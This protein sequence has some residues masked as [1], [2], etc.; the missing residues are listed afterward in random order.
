MGF[1]TVSDIFVDG[2]KS[3][4]A[5]NLNIKTRRMREKIMRKLAM[6]N[7]SVAVFVLAAVL[8]SG[9]AP[10]KIH[11]KRETVDWRIEQSMVKNSIERFN[12]ADFWTYEW[13]KG[14]PA[15]IVCD[16]KEGDRTM[17]FSRGWR[18]LN[19]PKELEEVYTSGTAMKAKGGLRLYR[20]EGEDGTLW[21]YFFAYQNVL[22]YTLVDDR[23]M[24][25]GEIPEP[26]QPGY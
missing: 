4:I 5:V 2:E 17:S 7:I 16:I 22:P 13:R 9:C 25:I 15:A 20:I 6:L 1:E 19:T 8:I 14:I 12:E 18:K 24:H 11:M 23:T 3:G 10:A 21:G 26:K